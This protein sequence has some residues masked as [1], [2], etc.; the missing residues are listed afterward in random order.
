MPPPWKASPCAIVMFCRVSCAP[1]ATSSTLTLWLFPL[2]VM[3]PPP[4]IVSAP[5]PETMVGSGELSVIVPLT[6]KVMV[7][8]ALLL[9]PQSPL[10]A[11]LADSMASRS[12]HKL[13]PPVALSFRVLTT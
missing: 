11:L 5:C 6:L 2:T 9:A 10:P 12:V 8:S 3:F 1:E 13:S 4:L 7:S